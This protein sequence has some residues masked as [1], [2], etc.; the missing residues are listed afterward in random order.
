M[1]RSPH[2]LLFDPYTGGHHG[3]YVR[4]L[5]EYWRSR[6]L[7]GRLSV[8]VPPRF[9]DLHTDVGRAAEVTPGVH[10]VRIESPVRPSGGGLRTLYRRDRGHGRVLHHYVTQLRPDHALMMYFDHIQFSLTLNLRFVFPVQLGGIYF[11]P[12]FHYRSFADDRAGLGERLQRLRKRAVLAAA[13]RNPHLTHVFCLDPY[14]VPHVESLGGRVRAVALPDGVRPLPAVPSRAEVRRRWDVAKDRRVALFFGTINAR[15]G[16]HRVMDALP[17]LPL[18]AQRQLCLAV[19]GAIHAPEHERFHQAIARV[20][21]ET[22]VQVVVEN[23]FVDEEEI[24][25]IIKAADLVLLPYQRHLGSSGVLVRASLAR[26]PVLSSNYGL[27][28]EHLRRHRLGLAVNTR[29]PD[30]LADAL[31]RWLVH[32][33]ALPF[34]AEEA[35]LFAHANTAERFAST[36]FQHLM[37][38]DRAVDGETGASASPAR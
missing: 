4:H 23:R 38:P 2:L 7:S 19:V 12:S 16:I 9:L 27:V 13:L 24:Q 34:D 3:E 32:P 5:V 37:P 18:A 20:R 28:G 35:R 1:R 21:A 10:L 6:Q 36:I 30:V 31:A 22:A 11:R 14:V 17:L 8:V 15:K 26:V 33:E 29:V 25:G